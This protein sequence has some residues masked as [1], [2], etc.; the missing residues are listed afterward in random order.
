MKIK[1]LFIIL[2]LFGMISSHSFAKPKRVSSIPQPTYAPHARLISF[3]FTCTDFVQQ[4]IGASP[5]GN[6]IGIRHPEFYTKLNGRIAS[7]Q[8]VPMRMRL[9]DPQD[10]WLVNALRRMMPPVRFLWCATDR[11]KRPVRWK[12]RGRC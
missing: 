4:R 8:R 11:A 7:G 3:T 6:I 5:S 1:Q 10:S 9:D 2:F 12:N